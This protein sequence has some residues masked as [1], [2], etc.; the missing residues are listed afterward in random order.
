MLTFAT[1]SY[2][3]ASSGTAASVFEMARKTM[4]MILI[5]G[6]GIRCFGPTRYL[7]FN[8]TFFGL[9]TKTGSSVIGLL[10]ER[11]NWEEEL[12]VK[13]ELTTSELFGD[14]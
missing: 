6:T 12:I 1:Q 7:F 13:L 8:G 2:T 9:Q 5:D 4:T 3:D 11:S 14:S 10:E